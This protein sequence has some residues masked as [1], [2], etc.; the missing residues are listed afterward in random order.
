M[1]GRR[2]GA[3][4]LVREGCGGASGLTS[5]E[6]TAYPQ[7]RRFT[8]A[9]VLHVFFTPSEDEVA[10]ARERTETPEA[11]LALAVALKCFQKMAR[12]CPLEE[13]PQPVTE[14]VRPLVGCFT[15]GSGR[16]G[17]GGPGRW[18]RPGLRGLVFLAIDRVVGIGRDPQQRER[19]A[20]RKSR[21]AG[22]STSSSW[23]ASRLPLLS[24]VRTSALSG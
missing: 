16:P 15:E 12:F 9:R 22:S 20:T 2:Y 5:I 13:V 10:W 4:V 17:P 24:A 11:L 18:A 8:T 7:F 3:C 23:P 14:H 6:R 1:P 19:A 21:S